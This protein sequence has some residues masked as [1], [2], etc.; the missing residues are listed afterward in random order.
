MSC[1]CLASSF[2]S[3]LLFHLTAEIKAYNQILLIGSDCGEQPASTSA[4]QSKLRALTL[5]TASKLV[6]IFALGPDL[7]ISSTPPSYGPLRVTD[8]SVFLT[9]LPPLLLPLAFCTLIS[10]NISESNLHLCL[11]LL[12]GFRCL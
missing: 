7:A 9:P 1:T 4:C 12:I 6:V 5:R 2:S 3:R 10:A 8:S 11:L